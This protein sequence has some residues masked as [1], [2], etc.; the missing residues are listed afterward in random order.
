MIDAENIFLGAS[1][2]GLGMCDCCETAVLEIKC[3]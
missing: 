3:P 1:P 2:D